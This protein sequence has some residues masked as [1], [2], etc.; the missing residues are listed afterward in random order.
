M[1]KALLF[2]VLVI[3][4]VSCGKSY[5]ESY[6]LDEMNCFVA[7]G[8]AAYKEDS[9]YVY[10]SYYTKKYPY[11]QIEEQGYYPGCSYSDEI[12]YYKAVK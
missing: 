2:V 11:A 7:V 4:L 12:R 5:K 3:A 8:Q 1:K 10:T 9:M 6:S